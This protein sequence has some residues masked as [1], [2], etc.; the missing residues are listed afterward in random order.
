MTETDAYRAGDAWIRSLL[1]C[2]WLLLAAPLLAHAAEGGVIVHVVQA[3]ETLSSIA[4]RYGVSVTAV[5]EANGLANP[6]Q[7]SIGQRLRIP[8]ATA[9][10]APQ[11]RLRYTVQPGDTWERLAQ[12]FR[13]AKSLLLQINQPGSSKQP[14]PGAVLEIPITLPAAKTTGVVVALQPVQPLQGEAAAVTVQAQRPITTTAR[15]AGVELAMIR[16]GEGQLWGL[17]GVHPLTAPGLAWLDLDISAATLPA[18]W[19]SEP[20]HATLRLRWPVQVT[21]G[22]FETQHLTLPPSKGGLLAPK[23]LADEREKLASIWPQNGLAPQWTAAFD[24]PLGDGFQVTSPFGTRRSYNGGPVSSF[25]EGQDFSASSGVPVMAPAV[26]VVVLAEELAVRGNAV[27]LDHGAGLHTGYWHL[28]K[29]DVRV[30]QKV[31]SGDKLGE[32]GTTGLST[33]SHLHWEMRIG[34]TPVDPL[35]WLRRILS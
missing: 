28:S 19:R 30:G 10:P 20:D 26:G 4:A 1:L 18:A 17:F 9:T 25:H 31:I 33:G 2:S 27:I 29:L 8:I 23:L 3:G 11:P 32:V 13:I 24:H 34:L 7:I 14:T 12:R 21:A 5:V 6:D 22:R 35:P 15:F 16:V